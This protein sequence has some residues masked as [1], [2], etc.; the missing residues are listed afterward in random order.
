[1]SWVQHHLITCL[2]CDYYLYKNILD[3]LYF[4]SIKQ[5]VLHSY[6]LNNEI[7]ICACYK[8]DNFLFSSKICVI[9]Y[10]YITFLLGVQMVVVL[11]QKGAILNNQYKLLILDLNCRFKLRV[12][13]NQ[14]EMWQKVLG[15]H[16]EKS[17][18]CRVHI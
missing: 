1:M 18:M 17:A 11:V 15:I 12:K 2:K 16:K 6:I 3:C 14:N 9:L 4:F 8:A 10:L 5:I 7:Y 13:T